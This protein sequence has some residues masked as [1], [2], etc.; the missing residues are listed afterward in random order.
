MIPYLRA[1]RPIAAVLLAVALVACSSSNN[2]GG[3][4]ANSAATQPPAASR[5]AGTPAAASAPSG[6]A[7]TAA[8]S[9][10]AAVSPTAASASPTAAGSPA[11]AVATET[12]PKLP[13]TATDKDGKGIQV[14]NI[15]RMVPL[16]GDITEII[17]ALGLGS[18][19][20]GVDISSTYPPEVTKLP[21][22]GYQRTLTAEPILALKPSL[23]V[24]DEMAGPPPVI[25]QLRGAGVPVVIFKYDATI[26]GIP[27]KIRNIAAALGVP[28]RGA[29]LIAAEQQSVNEAKALA[30]KATSKPKVAF[31]N[32][33]GGGTQQI[34][35]QGFPS[36][37]MIVAAGGV[38]A[39]D[40]AGIQGSKPITA[41]ALVTAAPDVILITSAALKDAGG[42]DGVLQI[43]GI[44]QTPAGQNKRVVSL[45]DQY[46]LGMGPR[47]GQAL[48]DLAKLLH[49]ELK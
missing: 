14:T 26:D 43:P 25:E 47:T 34:W 10:P 3:N 38:D 31:L 30:A 29:A 13:A 44:A 23:I 19:V 45:E 8:R 41:E 28:G 21:Q 5:A 1:L 4:K 27:T 36:H 2:I 40:A 42:V 46:L 11:A 35:G 49:P 7:A 20:A 24:G 12:A 22:I 39:A 48:S 16:D 33:R 15:D 32:I 9:S 18:N 37:D 17:Y 6:T